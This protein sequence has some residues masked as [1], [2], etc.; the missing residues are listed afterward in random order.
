MSVELSD[1][2]YVAGDS[3]RPEATPKVR[4]K[5]ER[6]GHPYWQ[7]LTGNERV[8][9]FR[10]LKHGDARCLLQALA[11]NPASMGLRAYVAEGLSGGPQ[12]GW[13]LRLAARGPS[14]GAPLKC[15]RIALAAL[16]DALAVGDGD[17]SMLAAQLTGKMTGERAKRGP[18]N[19]PMQTAMVG[20]AYYAARGNMDAEKARSAVRRLYGRSLGDDNIQRLITQFNNAGSK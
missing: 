6:I 17:V 14:G 16:R 12:T 10:W 20:L 5:S 9:V 4:F 8:A 19:D 15:D 13:R 18:V 2:E 1:D 11:L 3:E 7:Q